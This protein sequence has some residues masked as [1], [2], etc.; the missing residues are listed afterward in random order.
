MAAS[1]SRMILRCVD[2]ICSVGEPPPWVKSHSSKGSVLDLLL[3][4]AIAV[5][6]T[7]C[8]SQDASPLKR[9][10]PI[11]VTFGPPSF[12]SLAVSS[13]TFQAEMP[14]SR[15]AYCFLR[16]FSQSRFPHPMTSDSGCVGDVMEGTKRLK[17][18]LEPAKEPLTSPL[19]APG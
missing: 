16:T 5:E 15:P 10:L 12:V 19:F 3:K 9:L 2:P 1:G 18:E 11:L 4:A 8:C 17:S 14:N 6:L 7:S 13:S